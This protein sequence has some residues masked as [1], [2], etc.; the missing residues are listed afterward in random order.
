MDFLLLG[1]E[2]VNADQPVGS[3]VKYEPEFD[4]L[5]AEID[6]LSSPSATESTDWKKVSNISSAILAE[7]S[8]D[9]LVAS[10]FAVSRIYLNQ[11]DGL[12]VGLAVYHDLIEKFWEDL[13]PAKKRMKGR[14]N[15]VEWWIEKTENALLQTKPGPISSEVKEGLEAHLNDID[16]LLATYL[17]DPPSLRP[18]QRALDN[19]RAVSEEP[20]APAA[21]QPE[22]LPEP[23]ASG[24]GIPQAVPSEPEQFKMSSEA[25]A[26]KVLE[27]GFATIGE[28]GSYLVANFSASP[29]GYKYNRM[30]I[31]GPITDPP[32]TTDGNMTIIPA[33]DMQFSNTLKDLSAKE[34][35]KNLLQAAESKVPEL[36]FWLDLNRYVAEA[37][38]GLGD[39]YEGAREAVCQ[40]TAFLLH[41]LPELSNFLFADGTPFADDETKEW[42]KGIGLGSMPE[43]MAPIAVSQQD[44]VGLESDSMAEVIAN[45]QKLAKKKKL[46]DA[47]ELIQ[48]HLRNS[49]SKRET[50]LWRLAL[51]QILVSSK[52]V[53]LAIPHL[54][55]IL[56]DIEDFRLEKWDPDLALNGLK[57]ILAGFKMH[58]DQEIK[59]R[60]G[61][62]LSRIAKIDAVEALNLGK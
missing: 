52:K 36:I 47:I 1:K 6:K 35:F 5:Q 22:N 15:A 45:A 57:A 28:A 4:D 56:C 43:T 10:Y 48:T 7:K 26:Q 30:A 31:W 8:K 9:L 11:L 32:M 50:L 18:I 29:L 53:K 42:I 12:G 41:R 2:P 51:S 38:T 40:G 19:F 44:A 55:Q 21:S 61:E 39:K 54:E 62:I 46:K 34:E 58:P 17:P 23:G 60:S 14:I 49:F 25:D 33:P 13:F 20:A 3:D 16:T 24:Q 27:S 37:L 59:D